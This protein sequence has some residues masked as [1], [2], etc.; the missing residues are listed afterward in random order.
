MDSIRILAAVEGN[1]RS[2]NYLTSR[3]GL[4]KGV[5]YRKVRKLMA[6]GL[7]KVHSK[8]VSPEGKRI[9]LYGLVL[10]RMHL[11]ADGGG[12]KG[13]IRRRGKTDLRV[14]NGILDA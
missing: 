13:S 10:D 1:P 8:D 14:K 2:V 4:T 12:L 5:C 11:Q 3:F 7:L 6:L 9:A